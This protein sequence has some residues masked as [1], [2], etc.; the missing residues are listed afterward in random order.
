MVL[1]WNFPFAT[2]ALDMELCHR[3]A[4]GTVI[5]RCCFCLAPRENRAVGGSERTPSFFVFSGGG[6]LSVLPAWLGAL[7]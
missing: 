7:D 3:D 2:K 1:D 5:T 4:S 6:F